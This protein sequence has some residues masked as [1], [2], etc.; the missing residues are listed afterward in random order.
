M[1]D[2]LADV[3][4]TGRTRSVIEK[5]MIKHTNIRASFIINL[6]KLLILVISFIIAL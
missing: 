6:K 4:L 5:R 1:V 3:P 2:A